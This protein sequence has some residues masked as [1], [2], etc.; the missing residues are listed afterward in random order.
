MKINAEY[1]YKIDLKFLMWKEIPVAL[2]SSEII[3]LLQKKL[4]RSLSGLHKKRNYERVI[5]T[6]AVR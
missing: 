1:L 4:G 5:Y 3:A 2:F 6:E